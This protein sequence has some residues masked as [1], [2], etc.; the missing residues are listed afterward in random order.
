MYVHIH[1][2]TYF[3][4]NQCLNGCAPYPRLLAL[5]LSS[6]PAFAR[7]GSDNGS[8]FCYVDSEPP[9]AADLFILVRGYSHSPL[10]APALRLSR[11]LYH[12]RVPLAKALCSVPCMPYNANLILPAANSNFF[13]LR[14]YSDLATLE[15]RSCPRDTG[16]FRDGGAIRAFSRIML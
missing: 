3:R 15:T 2:H 11:F 14:S 9:I 5:V 7:T 10:L 4:Y 8:N 12:Y 6:N 1:V 16:G 13:T